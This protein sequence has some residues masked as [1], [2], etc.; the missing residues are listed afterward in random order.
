MVQFLEVTGRES[1]LIHQV[2]DQHLNFAIL[3][4]N[5][6]QTEPE[7]LRRQ[8]FLQ[9]LFDGARVGFEGDQA[10]ALPLSANCL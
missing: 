9:A 5:A 3:Q 2:G 7:G 6:D 4:L 8:A 1:L 10:C